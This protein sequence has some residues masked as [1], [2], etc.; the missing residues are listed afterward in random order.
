M[1]KG[2]VAIVGSGLIGS[3]WAVMFAR[4]GYTVQ[5]YDAIQSQLGQCEKAVDALLNRLQREVLNMDEEII[6]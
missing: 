3:T 6:K 5:V 4:F 2:H 1:N